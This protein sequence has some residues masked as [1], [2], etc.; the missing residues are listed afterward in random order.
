M[1]IMARYL[2]LS[3]YFN[4]RYGVRVQRIPVDAGFNCPNRDGS[5]AWGG[6]TFCNNDSFNFSSKIPIHEQVRQALQ[7]AGKHPKIKKFMLYFQ[8]YSNT[9]GPVHVLKSIYDHVFMDDRIVA[10]AVGTR[11]DCLSQ[12]VVDLLSDY[13]KTHEVWLEL[14]VQ[15]IHNKT[16][17]RVNRAE[18]VDLYEHWIQQLQD[19][20]IKVCVHI[21]LGLPGETLEDMRKTL[22]T[23]ATWPIDGVK[24]HNLH[25]VRGTVLS[26]QYRVRPWPLLS[27]EEYVELLCE[28]IG[29]LP[30]NIV[31]HRL[32]AETPEK[33]L[34]APAWAN[35]KH[36]ILRTLDHLL[37]KRDWFQGC[38]QKSAAMSI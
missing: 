11:A 30:E 3:R 32:V 38:C 34:V 13:T 16:L 12:P 1:G 17:E 15:T 22:R 31:I 14:G 6:C 25:I 10:L 9:Y 28:F 27:Q 7:K 29:Y 26:Y 37:E 20:P 23:V 36:A 35:D 8:P 19:T 33:L 2:T 4:E 24:C 5:R 18:T 21:L